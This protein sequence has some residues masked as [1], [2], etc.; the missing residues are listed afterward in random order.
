MPGE[1]PIAHQ[2]PTEAGNPFTWCSVLDDLA[3]ASIDLL[4]WLIDGTWKT[5]STV[6]PS[7][8]PLRVFISYAHEDEK[9][10][11]RL[12]T[13]IRP[14]ERSNDLE[15]WYDRELIPGMNL[16]SVIDEKVES[17]DIF[18]FIL[19]SY[20][21]A[22]DYCTGRELVRALERANAGQACVIGIHA[23]PCNWT[24]VFPSKVLLLPT[25]SKAVIKW[26]RRDDA[27]LTIATGLKRVIDYLS[28]ASKPW[29]A[30]V[31]EIGH[32]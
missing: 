11:E 16:D 12:K 30:M 25:D 4:D 14:F 21:L 23:R 20:F 2:F 10:V 26:R 9:F 29:T 1:D 22:S 24:E 6:L 28:T 19:S 8:K 5:E 3:A 13:E 15:L 17:A 7:S 31:P 18:V 27:W 32:E